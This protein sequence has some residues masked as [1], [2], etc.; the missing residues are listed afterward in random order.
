MHDMPTTY[1]SMF[2]RIRL[3]SKLVKPPLNDPP[4]DS[5]QAGKEAQQLGTL[6]EESVLIP[7]A[8]MAS[9]NLL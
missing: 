9:Y 6:A 8:Y 5:L 1:V 4:I 7:R 2:K 3:T